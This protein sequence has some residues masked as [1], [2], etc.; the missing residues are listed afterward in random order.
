MPTTADQSP[1]GPSLED[2]AKVMEGLLTLEEDSQ[3]PDKADA[4]EAHTRNGADD[5]A[6]AES[7]ETTASEEDAEPDKAEATDADGEAE[8]TADKGPLL[9]VTVDGKSQQITLEEAA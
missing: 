5:A 3:D 9:T 8:A 1:Q 2:A 6:E 7:K 4:E